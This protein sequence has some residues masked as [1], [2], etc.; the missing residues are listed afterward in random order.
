MWV[1]ASPVMPLLMLHVDTLT[2]AF[3]ILVGWLLALLNTKRD[4][5][6]KQFAD[7]HYVSVICTV[8]SVVAA[9]SCAQLLEWQNL[10]LGEQ[11][12]TFSRTW[13]A[14]YFMGVVCRAVTCLYIMILCLPG[15]LLM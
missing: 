5:Y 14:V 1:I 10:G 13:A 12:N 2:V 4:G 11:Y 3:T 9:T 15:V 6:L 8:S 7:R